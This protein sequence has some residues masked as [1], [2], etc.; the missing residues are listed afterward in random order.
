M[1]KN[2]PLF[3]LIKVD[4]YQ[5][6][7]VAAEELHVTQP[8][9]SIAIKNLEKEFDLQLITR[10][11]NGV[12]LTKDGEQIVALAKKAFSYI[13]EIEQFV[14]KKKLS[15]TFNIS[16]YSTTPLNTTFIS[17]LI[18]SYY[19]FC[20]EGTFQLAASSDETADDI[21]QQ[22][23]DSVVLSVFSEQ[24][25]FPD[26]IG[27]TVLDK[28]KTYL[29]L[30]DTATFVPPNVNSISIKELLQI[31]LILYTTSKEHSFQEDFLTILRKYGE[32]KIQFSAAGT[33][34]IDSL[35]EQNLGGA[36]LLKFKYS[37]TPLHCRF[38]SIKRMP[39]F[40]LALLYNKSMPKEKLDFIL[41][42][43][44]QNNH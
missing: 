27:F 21:L 32:P 33:K 34:L 42:L 22:H 28:S 44:E 7:T 8:T 26:E 17:K 25:T 43:I 20:P 30:S 18:K 29:A 13:D 31:P 15:K 11:H 1:L 35:I 19:Q 3:Y 36:P 16:L 5:S 9:I 38:V 2:D 10:T 6:L 24:T 41:A 14:R 37:S 23:P 40:I 12:V 39:K 4:Q